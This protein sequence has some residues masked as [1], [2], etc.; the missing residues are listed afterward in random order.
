[1]EESFLNGFEWIFKDKVEAQKYLTDKKF[2]LK[3]KDKD[4]YKKGNIRG[5]VIGI[6]EGQE[7]YIR[8]D[9]EDGGRLLE[10]RGKSEL[11]EAFDPENYHR[12]IITSV[13]HYMVMYWVKDE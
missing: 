5:R 12:I 9:I 1:M 11:A 7:R 6:K 13:T 4:I 3:D 10:R 2:R 8:K